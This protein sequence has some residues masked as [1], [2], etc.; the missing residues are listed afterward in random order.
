MHGKIYLLIVK[1]EVEGEYEGDVIKLFFDL[2]KAK[3]YI[4]KNKD[5]YTGNYKDI[6]I[7][8]L[9]VVRKV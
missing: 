7:F 6:Y 8:E 3:K 1:P 5:S 2:E 4:K 9:D